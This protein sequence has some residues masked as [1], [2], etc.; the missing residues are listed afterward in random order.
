MRLVRRG[1]DFTCAPARGET[2][3]L[4]GGKILPHQTHR[5]QP[6][7]WLPEMGHQT[8]S[9][10]RLHGEQTITAPNGRSHESY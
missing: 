5:S 7:S 6:G 9:S 8:D 4:N 10:L 1:R 3:K 2:F